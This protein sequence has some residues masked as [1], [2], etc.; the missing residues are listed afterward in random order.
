M[1]LAPLVSQRKLHLLLP[2]QLLQ[3]LPL[4]LPQRESLLQALP[5][6]SLQ[7]L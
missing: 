4:H 6:L 5:L 2:L 1:A 7:L 3:L